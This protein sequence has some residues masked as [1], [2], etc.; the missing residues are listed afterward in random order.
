MVAT[1]EVLLIVT[2]YCS[3]SMS[4][5]QFPICWSKFEH[6]Y[7]FVVFDQSPKMFIDFKKYYFSKSSWTVWSITWFTKVL[8]NSIFKIPFSF[9]KVPTLQKT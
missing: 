6:S 7:T 8:R 9:V 5:P 2:L 3:G 1:L 4:E